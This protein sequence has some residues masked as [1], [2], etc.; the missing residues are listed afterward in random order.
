MIRVEAYFLDDL[1]RTVPGFID[2]ERAHPHPQRGFGLPSRD[3]TNVT[4]S[5]A[6]GNRAQFLGTVQFT[7]YKKFS[8]DTDATITLPDAGR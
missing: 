6:F 5:F 7:D 2:A 8:V 1:H 4:W 3:E